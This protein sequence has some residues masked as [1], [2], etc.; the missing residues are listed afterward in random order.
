MSS[1][2][3]LSCVLIS[4]ELTVLVAAP[5]ADGKNLLLADGGVRHGDDGADFFVCP[6]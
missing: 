1:N 6:V 5:H 4:V 2:G 3:N